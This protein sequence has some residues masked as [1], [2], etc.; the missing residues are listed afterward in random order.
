MI[1]IWVIWQLSIYKMVQ[2]SV[3]CQIVKR[4][5]SVMD[6]VKI[7]LTVCKLGREKIS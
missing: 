6:I 4:I 5:L 3:N 1:L 2:M 7:Y